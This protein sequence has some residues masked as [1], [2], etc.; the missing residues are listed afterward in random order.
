MGLR[1]GLG[2]LCLIGAAASAAV[3]DTVTLTNGG[4]IHGKILKETEDTIRIRTGGGV[5]EL[6]RD[7]VSSIERNEKGVGTPSPRPRPRRD[8]ERDEAEPEADA[9]PPD[10]EALRAELEELG[11][12]PDERLAA[13]ALSG[14]ESR[15]LDT[16]IG[17]LGRT[18]RRGGNPNQIRENARDTIV[19]ELGIKAVPRLDRELRGSHYWR[20]RMAG[21]ALIRIARAHPEE[22]RWLLQHLDTPRAAIKLL[23]HKGEP[24]LSAFLRAEANELLEVATGHSVEFAPSEEEAPTAAE[25]KGQRDWRTWWRGA[26]R[27]WDKAQRVAEERRAEL[28]E[29]LDGEGR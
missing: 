11:P 8:G 23:G 27:E 13:L 24:G 19:A 28:R 6:A 22:G 4:E 20:A 26:K 2:A 17:K 12:G 18:G 16:L 21:S 7:K 1:T 25:K 14:E 29:A 9:P 15:Q 5:M 10:Q 3:A